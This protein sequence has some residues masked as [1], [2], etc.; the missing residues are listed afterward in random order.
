M[1]GSSESR[2]STRW[3]DL[4]RFLPA[5]GRLRLGLLGIVAFAGGAT[6]SAV[7]VL[8]A[9]VANAL[10]AA[11]PT[12]EI[13]GAELANTTAAGLA[14]AMVAVRMA[15]TL[16]G[17]AIGARF[18]AAAVETA[19]QDLL[20]AYLESSY[21]ARASRPL[22]D[23]AT[24]A[25]TNGRHVG[26]LANA[27]TIVAASG[28]GLVA[29]GLSALTVDAP[30]ALAIALVGTLVLAATRPLRRRQKKA[31]QG[32]AEAGRSLGREVAEAETLHRE[33][34]VFGVGAAV[35][36]RLAVIAQGGSE[37]F[38]RLRFL[39]NAV[40]QLFQ[41]ALVGSAVA[42]LL[43]LTTVG[44]ATDVSSVGAVVLLLLRSMSSAQQ[45]VAANQRVAEFGS[46]ARLIAESIDDLQD[47]APSSG[48]LVPDSLTPV[49]FDDVA[50]SYDD[51]TAA[52]EGLKLELVA[53]EMVGVVGP[54]GA[55]KSTFV[56]LLL[57]LR[58]PVA[59]SITYGGVNIHDLQPGV[60]ARRVALVPQQPALVAGTIFD[61]VAFYRD[62]SGARA[63]SALV[64]AGLADEVASLPDGLLTRLGA[65]D[66]AISGGQRQR[67]TIARALAGDPEIV[68]LDEPSSA[69]DPISEAALREVL[70]NLAAN[71]VVVVV[72]HRFSTLRSCDRI[73][74]FNQ[75]VL[76]ADASPSEL[77]G[78]SEYFRAM[79]DHES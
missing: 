36:Q 10:I 27:Y 35:H 75:G 11:A 15:S 50:F 29:F 22:G 52:L 20:R 70:R 26:D 38:R 13:L 78:R 76:E 63:Q 4:E 25:V 8:V 19:Q 51:V 69:L 59:G 31:A 42:A 7:L 77:A 33:I 74:V 17:A 60:F 43:F 6:E 40:P 67:L 44:G 24:L 37:R 1:I 62:I 65:D 16:L 2:T 32:F 14:L 56:D 45:L 68:V 64:D 55:G 46:F 48:S 21:S 79:I 47:A 58:Q 61:N 54:S 73:L 9:L 66:R 3:E 57:G 5:G 28:C 53:G 41:A 49:R 23:L 18:A 34:E 12:V 72:A 71:R 39:G 30:A